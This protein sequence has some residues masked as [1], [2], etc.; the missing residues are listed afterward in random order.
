[1]AARSFAFLV[2]ALAAAAGVFWGLKLFARPVPAPAQAE[3]AV[4]TLPPADLSRVLGVPVA[5]AE[6][7]DAEASEADAGDGRFV[8]VGVVAPRGA[9]ASRDG[10]ALIAVDGKPP[11]AYRVGAVIDGGEIVQAV[12]QR[13]VRIGPRGA[14]ARIAL[15]LPPLP[16]PATGVPSSAMPPVP[17]PP[18]SAGFVPPPGGLRQLPMRPGA[19]MQPQAQPPAPAAADPGEDDGSDSDPQ[20]GPG[21]APRGAA[22]R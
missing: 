7:E 20:V 17:P 4:R 16:P 21:A 14:P 5:P 2:W 15:E 6:E 22:V 12:E 3:V 9:P 13:G 18:P 1:M 8:L 11:K 19:A 10:V